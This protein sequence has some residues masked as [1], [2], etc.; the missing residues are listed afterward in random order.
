[1]AALPRN[2]GAGPGAPHDAPAT[3]KVT[4][5][6]PVNTLKTQEQQMTPTTRPRSEEVPEVT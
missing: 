4:E 5:R 3:V 6:S 1:M 2:N